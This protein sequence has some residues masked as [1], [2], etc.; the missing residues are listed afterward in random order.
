MFAPLPGSNEPEYYRIERLAQTPLAVPKPEIMPEG[1]LARPEAEKRQ[2]EAKPA[3]L[4]VQ[5]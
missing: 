5:R 4:T 3:A 2:I 1:A